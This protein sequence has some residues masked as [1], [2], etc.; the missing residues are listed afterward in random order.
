MPTTL[1]RRAVCAFA[2][3]LP[4]VTF[5]TASLAQSSGQSVLGGTAGL[6]CAALLCLSSSVG[7]A[8]S[9]CNPA[10]SYYFGINEKYLSDTIASRLNFLQQCPVSSQSSEMS[11]LVNAISRGA[12][13]CDAQ[14]F[15]ALLKNWRV[16]SNGKW[17]LEISNKAPD[18]CKAYQQHAYTDLGDTTPKYVGTVKEGGYWVEP[19]HYDA[20][21]AKY[22]AALEARKKAEEAARLSSGW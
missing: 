21:L 4:C 1:C 2:L 22:N 9:E 17:F 16:E 7:A 19:N 3:S 5:S 11:S 14:S 6:A 18:Y 13:R 10:L 20:E 12:G 15:N 8:Q